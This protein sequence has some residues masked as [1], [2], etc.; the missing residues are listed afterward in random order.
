MILGSDEGEDFVQVSPS[1][2]QLVRRSTRMHYADCLPKSRPFTGLLAGVRGRRGPETFRAAGGARWH[3]SQE[4]ITR[5][6]LSRAT[7]RD[8]Q[9]TAVRHS[10]GA[11]HRQAVSIGPT[12]V[13]SALTLHHCATRSVATTQ[14]S[15]HPE[16]PSKSHRRQR[17]GPPRA[18]R[19]L[20]G[21]L[22]AKQARAGHPAHQCRVRGGRK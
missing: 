10:A 5:C 7:G 6:P 18:A 9:S 20:C 16:L 22:M 1:L 3:R 19:S 21:R 2:S 4:F 15:R 11:W 12:P 17:L 13:A 8:R 14:S